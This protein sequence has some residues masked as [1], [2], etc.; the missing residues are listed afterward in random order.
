MLQSPRK[1]FLVFIA[2]V[3]L[4]GLGLRLYRLSNQS[5]WTDEISSL[6]TARGPLGQIFERSSELNALPPYFI[7]LRAAIG[8]S[9]ENIE[10]RARLISA[11]AGSPLGPA[12]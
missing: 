3:S 5:F 6:I 10:A 11:L 12:F 2:L 7:V 8:N 1:T 9:N 4:L